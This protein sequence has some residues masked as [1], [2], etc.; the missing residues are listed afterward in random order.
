VTIKDLQKVIE[1]QPDYDSYS[2]QHS[3]L[4]RLR[5]KEF[6][7]WEPSVHK[8]RDKVFKGDCCYNHIVGLPRKDGVKKPLF[9]YKKMLY[10]ALLR[11]GY[12]NSYPSPRS[13]NYD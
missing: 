12:L 1:S 13:K 6:W 10:K 2:S 9:D 4:E 5:G 8:Q 3:E 7:W 11:P